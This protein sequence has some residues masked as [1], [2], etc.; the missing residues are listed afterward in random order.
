M[1]LN[2]F[3]PAGPLPI[4][5]HGSSSHS[6]T[7]NKQ[8]D[9]QLK[10]TDGQKLTLNTGASSVASLTLPPLLP[11]LLQQSSGILRPWQEKS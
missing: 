6:V 5:V 11:H 4:N 9:Q 1:T 2:G 8:Q 10:D 7:A 3:G